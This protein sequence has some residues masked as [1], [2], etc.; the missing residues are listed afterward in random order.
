[1]VAAA[2]RPP[3]SPGPCLPRPCRG[4]AAEELR[5]TALTRSTPSSAG[6]RNPPAV[7]TIA[8]RLC[9]TTIEEMRLAT[10]PIPSVIAKPFTADGPMK[11]R[12]TQVMNV[13]VLESNRGPRAPDRGVDRGGDGPSRPD[14]FFE[15]LKDQHVGVD[16]H[17]HRGI[18]P[19]MPARVSVTGKTL[20]TAST[21]PA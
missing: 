19:V 6:R 4:P 8:S 1:M 12:M 14:L 2:A 5:Q 9:V 10:T 16:G 7:S 13:D 15:A 17:A 18:K 11:P 3:K 21:A 20:N